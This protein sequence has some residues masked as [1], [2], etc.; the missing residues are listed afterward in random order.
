MDTLS[1]FSQIT[2]DSLIKALQLLRR[3]HP[4]LPAIAWEISDHPSVCG[5]RGRGSYRDDADTLLAYAEALG[6]DIVPKHTFDNAGVRMQTLLLVAEFADV[7]VE[8][9][10]A[11][12]SAIVM[13]VAA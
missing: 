1:Q 6:G 3:T 5:L 13:A 8:I 2:Q 9:H 12:P 11:I 4:E 7:R 10:G